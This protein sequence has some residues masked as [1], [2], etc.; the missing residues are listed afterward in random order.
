MNT[1][2]ERKYNMLR[3]DNYRLMKKLDY[4]ESG[5]AFES[6]KAKYEKEI[7][8]LTHRLAASE[9]M[10]KNL[11]EKNKKNIAENNR[12]RNIISEKDSELQDV[13]KEYEGMLDEYKNLIDELRK[14]INDLE[15][16]IKKMSAQLNRDYTNSSIPYI[17]RLENDPF[18]V[19]TLINY[20]VTTE[21]VAGR[22]SAIFI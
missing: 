15:G 11:S 7:I 13:I 22:L 1:D 16:T 2:L 9:A 21:E 10:Y 20:G 6:L 8:R 14:Q 3:G 4:Y 18:D 17:S 5:K 12:L 19:N